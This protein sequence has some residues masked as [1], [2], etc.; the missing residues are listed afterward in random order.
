MSLGSADWR[1]LAAA[2]WMRT[3]LPLPLPPPQPPQ[4]G[5]PGRCLPRP[6]IFLVGAPRCGTTSLYQA[7][8]LNPQVCA[9]RPKDPT[10]AAWVLLTVWDHGPGIP[11]EA[12]PRIFDPFYRLSR[13]L[14]HKEGTGLG[15]YIT[16]GLVE[17]HGGQIW[18]DDVPGASFSMLW[19][20]A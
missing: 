15:L 17:A 13:D 8:R 18:L 12:L 5:S 3:S 20:A 4:R 2:T 1:S 14:E 6:G 9:A 19:P 16:R 7:L 11:Q 10:A